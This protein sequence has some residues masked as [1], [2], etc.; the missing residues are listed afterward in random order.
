MKMIDVI[1]GNRLQFDASNKET[2]MAFMAI[3]PCGNQNRK[4]D[5]I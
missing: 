2:A 3:K 1:D 4:H 5:D